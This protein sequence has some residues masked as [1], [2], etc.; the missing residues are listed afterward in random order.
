MNRAIVVVFALLL[1]GCAP[2]FTLVSPGPVAVAKNGMVVQPATSWNRIPKGGGD[3]PYE[4]SWTRNG[5]YLD[6]VA[7]VAGLPEGKALVE[8]KKKADKQVPVFRS[9]MTPDELVSMIESYYRVSGQISVFE[10]TAVEPV[11]F[12]SAPAVRLD[13][14]YVGGDQL[15]RKG[16]C[17]VGIADN[18]LYLMKLEGASSHYFGAA[19]PEFETMMKTAV[20]R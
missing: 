2:R 16:R 19:L 13:F 8:Q 5:P 20:V 9:D 12:L 7:F 14:D 11:T 18:K 1:A 17:V 10:V 3:I 6:T 4:E 15:P